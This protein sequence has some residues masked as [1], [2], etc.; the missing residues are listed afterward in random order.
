MID[1]NDEN[2]IDQLR[3]IAKSKDGKFLLEFFKYNLPEF[4]DI[5][6][7]STDEEAGREFKRTKGLRKF[8]NDKISFLT[9]K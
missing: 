3:R 6:D 9:S 1:L 7:E 2:T 4:D 8:I 5:K